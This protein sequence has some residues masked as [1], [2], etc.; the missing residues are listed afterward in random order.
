MPFIIGVN[1]QIIAGDDHKATCR[2]FLFSY[3]NIN[4]GLLSLGILG[5]TRQEMT[6]N[7]LIYTLFIALFLKKKIKKQKSKTIL[8]NL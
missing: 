7:K 1:I 3:I 8:F 2:E 4:C 6:D 5:A